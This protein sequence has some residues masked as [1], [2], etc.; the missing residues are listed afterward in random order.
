[1]T[2]FLQA[3]L[4]AGAIYTTVW[5]RPVILRLQVVGWAVAVSAIAWKYGIEAQ[6]G[7]YSNDQIQYASTVRTLLNW[8]WGTGESAT[9]FWWLEYS[10]IPYPMAALPLALAGVHVALALK[11]VSLIFLLALSNDLLRRY[12]CEGGYGQ[13]RILYITGCGFIGGFFSLLALRDTMMMYFVYRF[14]TDRTLTGRLISFAVI[15][16]LRSH[17][18]AALIAA[19][20]MVAAWT[21]VMSRRNLAYIEA[22]LLICGGVLVGIGLFYWNFGAL[23]TPGYGISE[24][25]EIV[26]NFVGLQFLTQQ[27]KF[28]RLSVGELLASRL[29]FSD[30]VV[31]P[32]A[33]TVICLLCGGIFTYRHRLALVAF[34]VYIGIV[35]N[36]DFNSFRQNIPLM[37]LMGML[38][39]DIYRSRESRKL[40][41]RASG[42]LGNSPNPTVADGRHWYKHAGYRAARNVRL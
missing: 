18:A 28:V 33:F 9:L 24:V 13:F 6:L 12:R 17:L 5:W 16:L 22:P 8:N 27:E 15:L 23:Q 26:S 36:T 39:L 40:G 4:I 14:A 42:E 20:I 41:M 2:Y 7:F 37:P 3:V 31:I 1:L 38:I 21:W 30:T 11:T 29:L 34:S 35:T 32:I 19:E 25:K 10:K